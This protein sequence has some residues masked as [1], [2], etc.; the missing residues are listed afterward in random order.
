MTCRKP[1]SLPSAAKGLPDRLTAAWESAEGWQEA[2]EAITKL[3]PTSRDCLVVGL[4]RAGEEDMIEAAYWHALI[5][6]STPS[7]SSY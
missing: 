7:E 6:L 5:W 2:V 3:L 4:S 1:V